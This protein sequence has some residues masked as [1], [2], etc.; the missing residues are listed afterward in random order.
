MTSRVLE[1]FTRPTTGIETDW[2]PL[3]QRQHLLGLQ[4]DAT[5][6]YREIVKLLESRLSDETLLTL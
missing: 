2:A 4:A 6:A 1:L 3:V 5:V